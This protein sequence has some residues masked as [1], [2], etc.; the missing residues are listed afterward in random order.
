MTAGATQLVADYMIIPC[1]PTAL[2]VAAAASAVAVVQAAKKPLL[3]RLTV[4]RSVPLKIKTHIRRSR[5]K[6]TS[7]R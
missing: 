3:L 7:A 1:Q 5:S 4:R 2:D 6:G